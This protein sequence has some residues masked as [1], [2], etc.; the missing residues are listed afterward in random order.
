M[1]TLL[2]CASA[3]FQP[4]SHVGLASPVRS[5]VHS[6]AGEALTISEPSFERARKMDITK[7]NW[8]FTSIGAATF[9]GI[10]VLGDSVGEI[11]PTSD[12]ELTETLEA[13]CTRYVFAGSGTLTSGG[14]TF[15][16]TTN[17][18]VKINDDSELVWKLGNCEALVLASPEYD[19]PERRL[20]RKLLPTLAKVLG[21]IGLTAV[22]SEGLA[23]NW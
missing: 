8:R 18:L 12:T 2:L 9:D 16:V 1:A 23:G 13:G 20:A 14:T 4:A 6:T 19:A 17:T 7:P 21:V 15:D 22:I 5:S 11:A 3:A 10:G